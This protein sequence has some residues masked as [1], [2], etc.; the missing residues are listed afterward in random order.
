VRGFQR[1]TAAAVHEAEGGT[2][3]TITRHGRPVVHVISDERLGAMLETME[4]LADPGFMRQLKRLK[5]GSGKFY[6]AASLAE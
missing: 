4:F 3:V 1:E 2:L 6:A 5:A